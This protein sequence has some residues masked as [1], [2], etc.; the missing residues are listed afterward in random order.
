MCPQRARRKQGSSDDGEQVRRSFRANDH[1]N[2]SPGDEVTCGDAFGNVNPRGLTSVANVKF[3]LIFP[4]Y[5]RN[6]PSVTFSL[7]RDEL[8]LCWI[9]EF[10]PYRE[11]YESSRRQKTSNQNRSGGK[12]P[13]ALCWVPRIVRL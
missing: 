12:R 2:G 13:I 4:C 6:F 7:H 11:N 8:S 9:Q 1:E 5:S 10:K 3:K